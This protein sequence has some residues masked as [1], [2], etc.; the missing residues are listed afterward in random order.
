MAASKVVIAIDLSGEACLLAL[1]LQRS[2]AGR[3]AI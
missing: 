2:K 1:K 3:P